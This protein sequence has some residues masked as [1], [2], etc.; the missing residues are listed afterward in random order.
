MSDTDVMSTPIF[1]ELVA[2][3][4]RR[5]EST[6]QEESGEVTAPGHVPGS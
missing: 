2:D 3:L 4:Q 5:A 6:E 1:D